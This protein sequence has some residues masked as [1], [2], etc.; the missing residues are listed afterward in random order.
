MLNA[1]HIVQS[2]GLLLLGLFLFAE[3]GLFLGFFLP[4][5]TL[6][7]AA[8]IFAHQGK[9]SIEAVII[10]AAVA[11]IA[12][13]ST[14]FFLGRRYGRSLFKKE[15]SLLFDPKHVEKAEKFYD[16]HGSKTMLIAHY[17]PVVRTFAPPLAG[18]SKM[19]YSKFLLYDAVGDISWAI[20]VTLLGY[21]IG[22][23]IPN[24]DHYI[25]FVV[26]LV[27]IASAAPTLYHVTKRY[28]KQR[29]A[30]ASKNDD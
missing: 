18:I 25:L 8:G 11:A 21:Y 29:K 12:G 9:F 7:I 4:G 14:S 16:K 27:V 17:L 20:I 1:T 24:I 5:D 30:K 23:K 22:S 6:L 2:G 10:V 26:A 3:V 15:N 28:L 13:D 19:P